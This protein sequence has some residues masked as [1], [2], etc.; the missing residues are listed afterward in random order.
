MHFL[1]SP[2]WVT[3]PP[4][5]LPAPSHRFSHSSDWSL[6][7]CFRH[8]AG[9]RIKTRS[10]EVE[11]KHLIYDG[12]GRDQTSLVLANQPTHHWSVAFLSSIFTLA[13]NNNAPVGR[14]VVY[15]I[16]PR[17]I[18]TKWDFCS[19]RL[20]S[21]D[22]ELPVMSIMKLWVLVFRTEICDRAWGS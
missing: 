6:P 11:H 16:I 18:F 5:P 10:F 4:V 20:F 1:A 17:A 3:V 15:E 2:M 22:L 14:S 21:L 12:A 9:R 7:L 8:T 13:S 19:R